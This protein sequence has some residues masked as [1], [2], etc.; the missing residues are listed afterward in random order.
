[1][2]KP[3]AYGPP[4]LH[5]FGVLRRTMDDESVRASTALG[6]VLVRGRVSQIPLGCLD[7][8]QDEPRV[9][10]EALSRGQQLHPAGAATKQRLAQLLL[11]IAQLPAQGGLGYVK[12]LGGT[13][14]VAFLGDGDK[15]A[16]LG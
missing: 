9:V 13:A 2:G 15:I 7:L 16:E 4:S 3:F 10:K 8:R 12:A 14:H 5:E 6:A 1:M 11:Q